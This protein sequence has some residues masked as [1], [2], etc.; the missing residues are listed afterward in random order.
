MEFIFGLLFLDSLFIKS[1]RTL[2]E[3]DLRKGRALFQL[4]QRAQ[5][6]RPVQLICPVL[7]GRKGSDEKVLSRG[8]RKRRVLVAKMISCSRN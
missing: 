7:I 4:A 2:P 6:G 8:H 3:N 1:F 5:S